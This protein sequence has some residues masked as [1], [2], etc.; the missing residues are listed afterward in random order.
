MSR[1]P[2]DPGT[3]TGVPRL[4]SLV[5]A[6]LAPAFTAVGLSLLP[7]SAE[8]ASSTTCDALGDL[9]AGNMKITN[10][11]CG[12]DIAGAADV[13]ISFAGLGSG[14]EYSFIGSDLSGSA[15]GSIGY[16]IEIISGQNVFGSV[17]LTADG[18][19]NSVYDAFKDVTWSGGFIQL[20]TSQVG[21]EP[22]YN[23][24]TQD[25]KKLTILDSWSA[26]SGVVQIVKNNFLQ[27]PGQGPEEPVPGPLPLLGAAAALGWS[28]RLRS[29]L[30]RTTPCP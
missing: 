11:T 7:V 13:M 10:L 24:N 12:G 2:V 8:A 26:S 28:R 21:L 27:V 20:A 19:T 4:L 30:R 3:A 15:L 9:I 6:A 25:I 29:R 22:V 1:L 14:V 17:Q 18:S 16:D 5:G 23:F